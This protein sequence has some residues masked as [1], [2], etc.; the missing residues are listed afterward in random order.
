MDGCLHFWGDARAMIRGE[1]AVIVNRFVADAGASND[2]LD[3]QYRVLLS[4]AGA[5]DGWVQCRRDN[6]QTPGRWGMIAFGLEAGNSVTGSAGEY[7]WGRVDGLL[8]VA[9][10]LFLVE[11]LPP[12]PHPFDLRS[13]PSG[14]LDVR[15]LDPDGFWRTVASSPIAARPKT[16]RVQ[17]QGPVMRNQAFT[18]TVVPEVVDQ[19]GR[20]QL[21][22]EDGQRLEWNGAAGDALGLVVVDD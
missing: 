22:L 20:A 7:V 1:P 14:V 3:E 4:H 10:P 6:L 5:T 15:V 18:F 9:G 8:P 12:P 21:V 17:T 19:A 16:M 2:C 11:T 13:V